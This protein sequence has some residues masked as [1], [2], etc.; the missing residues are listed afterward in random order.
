[1]PGDL[2]KPIKH[3]S[4]ASGSALAHFHKD[5]VLPEF[6]Q[7][8]PGHCWV[9]GDEGFHSIDSNTFGYIPLG[10]VIGKASFVVCPL[11]NFGTVKSFIPDWKLNRISR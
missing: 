9:E 4:A 8:P 10:L 1:M 7:I 5:Q 3:D 6:L 2:V 11:S